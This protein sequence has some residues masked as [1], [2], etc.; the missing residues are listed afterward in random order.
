M[1]LC[2]SSHWL[3]ETFIFTAFFP[4]LCVWLHL[5]MQSWE[6]GADKYS[7]I[8]DQCDPVSALHLL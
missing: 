6:V 8:E 5:N 1:S 2:E 4:L 3:S 7:F